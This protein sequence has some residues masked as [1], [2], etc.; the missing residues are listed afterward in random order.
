LHYLRPVILQ[1]IKKRGFRHTPGLSGV[2]DYG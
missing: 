1:A 2:V